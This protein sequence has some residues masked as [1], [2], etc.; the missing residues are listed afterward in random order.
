MPRFPGLHELRASEL[1]TRVTASTVIVQPISAVEQHGPHLP[2]ATDLIIAAEAADAFAAEHGEAL[3]CLVLPPL[4]YG[5]SSEHEWCP[6]TVSLRAT[7]LLA[8]L[9]DLGRSLGRL[10]SRK[11]V[12]LNGHGGNTPLLQV[13]CREIRVATGLE[14]FLVHPSLPVDAGGSGDAREHG[15]GIHAGLHETSLMLHLR[16]ELVDMEAAAACLPEA[17]ATNLYVRFDGPVAFGWT[18][19]DFGPTGIIGDPRGA[20]PELGKELFDAIVT[21]LAAALAEIR[22]F[23]FTSMP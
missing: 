13:A 3:G 8:V 16:P 19:R 21:D 10:A 7:T 15:L 4:A 2:L 22:E 1:A 6:G 23:S 14:T 5:T 17:L 11:L 9:Q 20:T 12:L 18:S